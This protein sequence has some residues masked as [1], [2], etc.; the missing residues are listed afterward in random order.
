MK[1]YRISYEVADGIWSANLIWANT[2]EREFEAVRDTARRYAD[3]H[4]YTT[5]I[6]SDELSEAEVAAELR[7][8]MPMGTFDGEAERAYDPS[9]AG[10]RDHEKFLQKTP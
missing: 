6:M 9:F 4:G 1:T 3:R 10:E 2:G 7:K 5:F 8:G